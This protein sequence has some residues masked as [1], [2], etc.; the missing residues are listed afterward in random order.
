MAN[1]LTTNQT[2]ELV[3]AMEQHAI[4]DLLQPLI[5]EIHLFDSFVAGTTHLSWRRSKSAINSPSFAR[6]TNSTAMRSS[7]SRQTK[8]NSDMSPRRTTSSLP[9]C[10]T[11]AKCWLPRSRGSRRKEAL[12]K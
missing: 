6:T 10:W 2:G 9:A 7:S 5:R 12:P 8:R 1:E 3:L 11:P 4:G